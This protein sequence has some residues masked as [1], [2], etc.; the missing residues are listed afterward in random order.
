MPSY[1]FK[2]FPDVKCFSYG[3]N[4]HKVFLRDGTERPM[5]ELEWEWTIY[6]PDDPLRML[7]DNNKDESGAELCE[8]CE[9]FHPELHKAPV[10]T[11]YA[12]GNDPEPVLCPACTAEWVD[13]WN[14][15]WDKYRSSQGV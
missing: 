13:N 1:S 11:M 10:M 15:M 5:T 4:G 14:M 2:R 3:T 8:Q 9:Q 7:E 12:D 6:P